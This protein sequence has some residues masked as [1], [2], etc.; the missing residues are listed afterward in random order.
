MIGDKIVQNFPWQPTFE[1]GLYAKSAFQKMIP[2]E[3]FWSM[4]Y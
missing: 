3:N 2:Q 4:N 1:N